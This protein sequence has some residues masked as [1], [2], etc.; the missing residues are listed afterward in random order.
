MQE[1]ILSLMQLAKVSAAAAELRENRLPFISILTDP[2]TAGVM[3]SFASLGDV[4]VAEP[5]ALIGF[6]GPRVIQD[7]IR[8]ELPPGFQRA[9]FVLEHGFVDVVAHRKEMRDTVGSLVD[10]FYRGTGGF[11][12]GAPGAT[13]ASQSPETAASRSGR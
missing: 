13:S 6:A 5:G 11:T 2:S 3:A 8:E 12:L 7:T 10:Y 1:G 9:D 4:I